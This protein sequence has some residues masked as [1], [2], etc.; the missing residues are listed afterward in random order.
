MNI[1]AIFITDRTGI[2][3][4]DRQFNGFSINEPSLMTGLLSAMSSVGREI[5]NKDIANLTFGEGK[6]TINI[7]LII[8]DIQRLS[9]RIF[10]VF[11]H[12]HSNINDLKGMA[13]NIFITVKNLFNLKIPDTQMFK[14]KVDKLIDGC[15]QHIY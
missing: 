7:A 12:N 1:D 13:T 5:F 8:K 3:Y 9:K 4:Y 15:Y 2:N 14:Q 10:F 11:I 6:N